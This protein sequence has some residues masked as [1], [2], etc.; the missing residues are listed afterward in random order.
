MKERFTDDELH[1]LRSADRDG[2]IPFPA[3]NADTVARLM[4]VLT[5]MEGKNYVYRDKGR[6]CRAYFLT[7]KG[8]ELKAAVIAKNLVGVG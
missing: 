8:G 5:R 4:E 3:G 6:R 1:L 2:L 7:A